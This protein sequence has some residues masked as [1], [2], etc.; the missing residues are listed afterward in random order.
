MRAMDPFAL[1]GV[2]RDASADEVKKAFR[3][4]IRQVHPDAGGSAEKFQIVQQAYKAAMQMV[5][6]GT[7]VLGTPTEEPD[8][9]G[10]T[11]SMADF[12]KWRRDQVAEEREQ[13]EKD[14]FWQAQKAYQQHRWPGN[15]EYN[16]EAEAERRAARLQQEEEERELREMLRKQKKAEARVARERE[17]R[18]NRGAQLDL[19]DGDWIDFLHNSA[20]QLKQKTSA[21]PAKEDPPLAE[22]DVIVSHRIVTTAKGSVKVPV[23]QASNGERYY[24]SPLTSK[25]IRLPR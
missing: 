11:W 14:A 22:E 13:W 21:T 4:K 25:T 6:S 18:A 19:G 5:A 12:W 24:K 1:L 9:C 10:S 3:Q 20:K 16:A 15:K 8:V 17:R 23:Y 7:S 2:K